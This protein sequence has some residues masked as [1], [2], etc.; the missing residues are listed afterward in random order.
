MSPGGDGST[1]CIVKEEITFIPFSQRISFGSQPRNG[2]PWTIHLGLRAH[3]PTNSG[4]VQGIGLEKV[5]AKLA[6]VTRDHESR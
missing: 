1:Q 2:H 4:F 6:D 3:E 5:V